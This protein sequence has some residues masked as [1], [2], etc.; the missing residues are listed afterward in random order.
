MA[1]ADRAQD[2]RLIEEGLFRL[3]PDGT[4]RLLGSRCP[5]CGAHFFP[6][7][8]VCLA[9]SHVGLAEAELSAGG[10]IYSYTIARQTPPGSLLEA[11]YVIAQVQLPEQVVVTAPVTGC[12]IGDVYVGMPVRTRAMRIKEQDGGE[13]V[14]FTFVPEAATEKEGGA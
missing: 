13:I 14:S 9:C 1:T 10:A 8:V 11:P 3:A 5:A 12:P 2:V 6:R 7:R 4:P